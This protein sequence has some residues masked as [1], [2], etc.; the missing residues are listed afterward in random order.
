MKYARFEELPV[1]K[2]AIELAVRVFAFT[3]RPAFR[4]YRSIR[5]Q[6]ERA[7]MSISNNIAEGFERG[8]TQETLTFSISRAAPQGKHGLFCASASACRSSWISDLRSQISKEEQKR[9]HASFPPGQ[10]PYRIPVFVGSVISTRRL[11][12]KVKKQSSARHS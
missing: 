3:K 8:T 4:S 2:D 11:E 9:S 6:I 12:P 10:T 5:D 7:S 1:W